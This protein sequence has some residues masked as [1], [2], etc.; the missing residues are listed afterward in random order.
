[1]ERPRYSE[2]RYSDVPR[3][4]FA[5]VEIPEFIN[6]MVVREAFLHDTVTKRADMILVVKNEPIK[7]DLPSHL[8]FE[9]PLV[10]PS[11]N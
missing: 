9:F 11:S 3:Q 2:S 6:E 1:M 5:C 8:Y 4:Y 7:I 10:S